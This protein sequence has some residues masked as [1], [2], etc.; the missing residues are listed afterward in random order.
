MSDEGKGPQG[1]RALDAWVYQF[2]EVIFELDGLP[3]QAR[4]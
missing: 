2:E 4:Q 3:G 1:R